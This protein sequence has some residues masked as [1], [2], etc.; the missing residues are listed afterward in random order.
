MTTR[1]TLN[2][3]IDGTEVIVDRSGNTDGPALVWLHGQFG[4]LDGLPGRDALGER[5]DVVEVHLPGWGVA[6]GGDRFDTIGE[7]A[8]MVWWAIETM[9]LGPVSLAGHGFGATL[10]VE[11][12]IQQP[13]A[14]RSLGL[15]APFGFFR[16]D[17]PG[18]DMFA[19]IPRDLQP[20]LYADP[21]SDIIARHFPPPADAY[22]KGL[23]AIRRVQTLGSTSRYLFPI[24]DTNLVGRA[25]RVADVPMN[26]WF[27]AADGVVPVALADDWQ[28]AFPHA[29]ITVVDGT[30]HMVAYE[31]ED[32]PG[33]L[34]G[35]IE[36]LGVAT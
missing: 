8:S 33:E 26:I 34:M 36:A 23:A 29:A 24:P 6:E 13:S 19:L 25:Y 30:A 17:D 1:T 15:A 32:F 11:L 16:A 2:S 3:P 18:V 12:A 7:L 5:F 20:H 35:S 4:A 14:V 27:G 10:A 31:H 22:D 28:A 21:S 9:G